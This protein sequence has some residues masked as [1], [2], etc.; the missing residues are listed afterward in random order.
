MKKN[1]AIFLLTAVFAFG[2]NLGQ[3]SAQPHTSANPMPAIGASSPTLNDF[4]IGSQASVVHAT[5]LFIDEDSYF[6]GSGDVLQAVVWGV[7]ET[8][9]D[10]SVTNSELAIIPTVGAVDV[11]GLTLRE[12]KERILALIKQRYRARSV[13]IFMSR[14]KDLTV[15]VHGQA[16]HSGTH[17]VQGNLQ[18]LSIIEAIGGATYDANLREVQIIHPRHGIRIVDVVASERIMGMPSVTLRSGDAIFIPQRDRRVSISGDVHHPGTFDFIEGDKLSNII[19]LSGGMFSSADSS[20]I[21]ITRFV[22]DNRDS[23][24]KITIGFENAENFAM[25][26]DDMV[27]ISRRAQYRPVRQVR[28]S[29]EVVFPGIYVIHEN[30]TRL[31]DVIQMAGGFTDDAF[32]GASRII[33][34]NFVNSAA[35]EQRKHSAAQ[36]GLQITPTESNFLRFNNTNETRMSVNFAELKLDDNTVKNMILREN[37]EIII[38]KND[39]TVSVIGAVLRPGFVDFVEGRDVDFFIE[40]AGGFRSEAQRRRVK[41]I[42]A[43]TQNRLSLRDVE[44][45][46]RG[47][48]IWVP[49]R[50]F[51]S[52]QERQQDVAIRS[53][54]LS[55]VGSIATT[56]TAAITVLAFVRGD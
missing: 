40:Q 43:G 30:Q 18:L 7:R 32:L 53:G 48:V 19:A 15:Q 10:I 39:W 29:G 46:E 45:I 2:Q 21:S 8:V 9:L 23:I 17:V 4:G 49:E 20:R 54:I 34:R 27:M 12:A 26:R 36:S 13:D 3:L 16:M 1:I 5:S 6:L 55:I 51:V 22:G 52:R 42:K 24:E 33:R 47:D 14:V 28:I 35:T 11:S 25:Q 50:D 56:I 41:V 38:E 31:I 37:D 44:M